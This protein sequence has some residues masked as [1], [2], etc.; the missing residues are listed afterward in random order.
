MAIEEVTDGVEISVWVVPGA[1]RTEIAGFHDGALRLRV[2]PPPE[3]GAATAAATKLLR[4]AFGASRVE[5][6]S[7]VTSRRKRFL[8]RSMSIND[9]PRTLKGLG[10]S[11]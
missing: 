8:L 3:R 1:S 10:I 6:V 4:E 11:D 7:G 9:A 5:L 2:G